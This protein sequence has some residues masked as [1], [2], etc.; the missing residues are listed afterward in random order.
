MNSKWIWIAAAA[1]GAY[2]LYEWL[3]TACV[4]GGSAQQLSPPM[5]WLCALAPSS[6]S[7][8]IAAPVSAPATTAPTA[9]SDGGLYRPPLVYASVLRVDWWSVQHARF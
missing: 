2:A 5:N 7:P 6:T 1:A 9:D 8:T 4:S 3:Q